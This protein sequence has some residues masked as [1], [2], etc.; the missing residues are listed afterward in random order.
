MDRACTPI[1]SPEFFPTHLL[2]SYAKGLA[3]AALTTLGLI[4]LM[5]QL[6]STRFEEPLAKPLPT[7]Q[8]IDITEKK[9]VT[10]KEYEAPVSPQEV[11]PTL[12]PPR[13]KEDVKVINTNTTVTPPV[14]INEGIF[15]LVSRDPLPVYKP[16]PRYPSAALRRGIEGYVIVEFVITKTGAVRNVRVVAGYDSAGN[17]T[18]VF[19][20]S[21]LAAAE[22]FKYQP[23]VED[24][25]PVERYGV[26][27]RIAY[28]LAQ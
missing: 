24:G 8:P 20:R 14:V 23:Q 1:S 9:V 5:S 16:A 17:A 2:S 12:Q 11:P 13:E 22:R 10:M 28:K 18:S 3:Y 25:Q 7:I 4:F 19:N 26:R 21:A 15:D 27:N 6:I